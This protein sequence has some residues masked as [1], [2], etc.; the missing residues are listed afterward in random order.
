MYPVS[1]HLQRPEKLLDEKTESFA[2]TCLFQLKEKWKKTSQGEFRSDGLFV[3]EVLGGVKP[4]RRF[5]S[6]FEVKS[7][8][9]PFPGKESKRR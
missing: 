4:L 7:G 3:L 6:T 2:R 8:R 9:G 1:E 5:C